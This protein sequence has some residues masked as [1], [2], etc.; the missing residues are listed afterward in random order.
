MSA[1]LGSIAAFSLALAL[2]LSG[3]AALHIGGKHA[4]L[5][6]DPDPVNPDLELA[7]LV[8]DGQAMGHIPVSVEFDEKRDYRL[9]FSIEG[10]GEK[11]YLLHNRRAGAVFTIDMIGGQ[12]AAIDDSAGAWEALEFESGGW[13]RTEATAQPAP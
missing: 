11:S 6:S 3:C 10:L 4:A 12:P 1:R 8:V 2:S 5:P 9:T 7:E 13:G